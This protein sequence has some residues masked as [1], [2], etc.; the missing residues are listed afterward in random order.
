MASMSVSGIVSGMDWESMIDEIITAAAKPAQVQVNK[1]TNLVN[2]KSLFEEMKVTVQSLQSTLS[3]LKLPSTYKA[4]ELDIERIDTNGSYKGVLTASVN[5]DAAVN[6]YDLKV[7]RLATAQTNRSKQITTSTIA[8]AMGDITSGKIY[9]NMGG[10]QV[11]IDVNASDSLQSLKSR[12]NTTLK[13]MD[14]PMNITASVVDNKLVLKSDNTGLGTASNTETIKYSLNGTNTLQTMNVSDADLE[15]GNFVIRDSKSNKVDSTKYVVVNGN[16]IRW[17][18]YDEEPEDRVTLNKTVNA[19]YTMAEGDV[20]TV[21]G[22]AGEIE[23]SLNI[24]GLDII[25]GGTLAKRVSIKDSK[26]N[27]Y[28]YGVDF[29]LEDGT[30]KWLSEPRTTYE[31]D[32]YTVSYTKDTTVTDEDSITKSGETVEPESYTVNY[33]QTTQ[34]GFSVSRT[35]MSTV[36]PPETYTISYSSTSQAITRTVSSSDTT[37]S[38]STNNLSYQNVSALGLSAPLISGTG[39]LYLDPYDPSNPGWTISALDEEHN[40][41]T[42][43][44]DFIFRYSN[45]SSYSRVASWNPSGGFFSQYKSYVSSETSGAVSL[46]YNNGNAPAQNKTYTITMSFNSTYTLGSET[47]DEITRLA[48]ILK[49]APA[50]NLTIST[51][52]GTLTRGVHYNITDD[53]K[54]DWLIKDSTTELPITDTD[55]NEDFTTLQAKYTEATGAELKTITLPDGD[56]ILRTYVD[57]DDPSL[58]KMEDSNGNTYE[59]GRDYV[60]RVNDE[61]TGYRFDWTFEEGDTISDASPSVT[62]YITYK[63]ISTSGWKPAPADGTDYFFG[64]DYDK[65]TTYT[66]EIDSTTDLSSGISGLLGVD[67]TIDYNDVTVSDSTGTYS[68]GE[69]YYIYSDGSIEWLKTHNNPD[70]SFSADNLIAAYRQALG[71]DDAELPT[72]ALTGA[73]GVVRSYVE[74]PDGCDFTLTSSDGTEYEYG[75]DYVLRLNDDGDGYVVSWAIT[76]DKNGDGKYTALDVNEEIAAYMQYKNI[77]ASSAVKGPDMNGV[78]SYSFKHESKIELTSDEI[79]ADSEDKNLNL[80]SLL[81]MEIEADDEGK[82]EG[83]TITDSEGNTYEEGTHFTVDAEGNIVWM[84]KVSEEETPVDVGATVTTTITNE[85][86]SYTMSYRQTIAEYTSTTGRTLTATGITAG[87]TSLLGTGFPT[88]SS[89]QTQ[90]N[91]ATGDTLTTQDLTV[92]TNDR[93]YISVDS[94]I[95]VTAN[96][97]EYQNGEDFVLLTEATSSSASTAGGRNTL[98]IRWARQYDS[99]GTA[100]NGLSSYVSSYRNATGQGTLTDWKS[101][102]AGEAFTLTCKKDY[103]SG[104]YTDA[105]IIAAA[106]GDYS[107]ITLT[108]TDSNG[109]FRTYTYKA[110]PDALDENSFTIVNGAIQWYTQTI[111]EEIPDDTPDEELPDYQEIDEG[112]TYTLYYEAFSPLQAEG[113]YSG[114]DT[115]TLK[116]AVYSET[117]KKSFLSYDDILSDLNLTDSSSQTAIDK[118]FADNFTITDN[119]GNTYTYGTDFVIRSSD[120]DGTDT[121]VISWIGDTPETD[122]SSNGSDRLLGS[123]PTTDAGYTITYLGRGT[124]GETYTL[125]DAVTRSAVDAITPNV[126]SS[127]IPLYSRFQGA[128]EIRIEGGGETYYMGTDF[129]VSAAGSRA[130]I[131]WEASSAW[132]SQDTSASTSYTIYVTKNGVTSTYSGTRSAGSNSLDMTALDTPQYSDFEAGSSTIT[133]GTKTFY[134]GV[135]YEITDND[136]TA[137]VKWLSDSEGGYEWYMPNPGSS[138][139]INLTKSD[140]TTKTYE[141]TRT[142]QDILNMA[143]LGFTSANGRL[144]VWPEDGLA[145]NPEAVWYKTDDDGNETTEIDTTGN[146]ILAGTYGF[147]V[148]RGI[149]GGNDTVF[150]FNWLAPTLTTKDDMPS[151]GDELTVEYEYDENTFTLTDDKGGDLIAALGLNNDVTEA[152]DAELELDGETITRSSNYIGEDY[153]NEIIKGMTLQLKG[154][155]EVSLDISHN[156]EK[157]VESINS[158]VETYNDLM[159]WINTRMSESQVDEDTAATIDSDDFRMRWGLLHGNSLLR[160]TKSQMRDLMAKTFTYS[161]TQRTSSEEIYGTMG[162][163]GLKADSTLRLRVG[164]VY[165]D[166]TITPSM[167]IDDIVAKISDSSDPETRNLYYGEDGQLLEQPLVKASVNDDK[168]VISSTSDQSITMSGSAAMKALKMNYTYTG[169]FQLGLST[170]STDYGKSGELEFDANTF[171]EALEDNPDEVQEMMLMFA[172]D[173]DSWLKSMLTSSASGETSGTLTRQIEDIQTQIDSIDEY[174]EKYQ[175]RLDRQEESLRSRYADAEEQFYKMSQQAN[176]IAAILNQLNGYTSSSS[177]DS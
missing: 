123:T 149:H 62:A 82:H 75:R 14:N 136:G 57:P 118:K 91:T 34:A 60:L 27:T 38:D 29:V 140:G 93:R 72:V 9:V 40:S 163:N 159:S 66:A 141:A 84:S 137:Q 120:D 35:K 152:Q 83:L 112:E 171:M 150:S 71:S 107:N 63:N 142:S 69:D 124:G 80:E 117:G 19:K 41:Y 73:D 139:T 4:K 105:Q 28:T 132:F 130:S 3:P 53:G 8:S 81:G 65:T 99:S 78:Y 156:A 169:L 147:T 56:G 85:P 47:S 6:V 116:I 133:Q 174:L 49:T 166:L 161:F 168:L 70:D 24:D 121:P 31:P 144:S 61:G 48:K 42:Y 36:K 143:D 131:N 100:Q 23:A 39:N 113:T 30:V 11:G 172:S 94:A 119:S 51:S 102:R 135:D 175:D 146:T 74:F 90:Y 58:F 10:R 52:E 25:D 21:T 97:V 16:E 164:T 127:S 79:D 157:A 126:D 138:Y 170:T 68:F 43:G 101:P 37:I 13:T 134:E 12:I 155:G 92:G 110:D 59:Y 96:G 46:D 2:K 103:T 109:V 148:T 64:F 104:S 50:D 154:I 106:S 44:S 76:E 128:S 88:L 32:S 18:Q 77:S 114:E 17:K 55:T 5:A 86:E 125:N 45:T 1:R 95:I 26:G 162:Y 145:Y 167:T 173:M 122:R 54:I 177:S 158:F 108:G 151:S 7:N 20:F 153:G 115:D 33:S 165:A 89:L 22:T 67:D 87:F 98:Q 176:S 15:A 129:T 111:E 160:N